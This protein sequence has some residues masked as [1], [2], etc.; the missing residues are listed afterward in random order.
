MKLFS[1]APWFMTC[2]LLVALNGCSRSAGS[3]PV[4][5]SAAT[6]ACE[7]FLEAWK[8]GMTPE[9]LVPRIH[10]SDY[11]WASGYKLIDYELLPEEKNNGTSLEISANLTL[12]DGKG[13]KKKSIATYTVGTSPAVT[14]IRIEP[15]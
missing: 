8:E 6:Q 10:G 13:S 9:D 15:Q 5:E 2:L 11:D 14:V 12:E 4:N 3:I 1:Y 7:E